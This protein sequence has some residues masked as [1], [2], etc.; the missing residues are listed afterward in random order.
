MKN[1]NKKL[2]RSFTEYCE[3]HPEMRFW[4]ALR[5]WSGYPFVLVAEDM[6]LGANELKVNG[7]SILKYPQFVGIRDTFHWE[8]RGGK[9]EPIFI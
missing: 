1:K 9:K 4:Q 5:N 7:E 3:K 2:L 6:I 8:T